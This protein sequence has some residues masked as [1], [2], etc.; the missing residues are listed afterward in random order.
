MRN[1]GKVSRMRHQNEVNAV[2]T[3]RLHQRFLSCLIVAV[4]AELG[5]VRG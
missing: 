3:I 2:H 5:I 1:A 4:R